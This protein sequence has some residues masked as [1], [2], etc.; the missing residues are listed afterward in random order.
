MRINKLEF[1]A[2][3]PFPDSHC[4]D[5]DLLGDSALFLIDGP[6]GAGKSTIIDA[7]TYAI[8]GE[9]AGSASDKTRIRSAHASPTMDT[10]V[11][12]TFSTQAGTFRVRRSPEYLKPAKKGGGSVKK[13]Q[14]IFVEEQLP[15]GL[16]KDLAFQWVEAG[17]KLSE[18]VGLTRTQFAQTV[19]LPQGEFASFLR[20]ETAERQPLLEQIFSTHVYSSVLLSLKER[21]KSASDEAKE[22]TSSIEAKLNE[23]KGSANLDSET[24]TQLIALAKNPEEDGA[25]IEILNGLLQELRSIADEAESKSKLATAKNDELIATVNQR[26][27]EALATARAIEADS[28]VKK[29]EDFLKECRTSLESKDFL[30]ELIQLKLD[31]SSK[32][33]K[34]GEASN[35]VSAKAGQLEEI[36]KLE[37]D[38]PVDRKALDRIKAKLFKSKTQVEALKITVKTT[39]PKKISATQKELDAASKL[40]SKLELYQATAIKLGAELKAFADYEALVKSHKSL[41]Q[42]TK[43]RTDEAKA[44]FDLHQKLFRSRMDNLAGHLASEL[45]KGQPCSVCGSKEH[46]KKAKP[47]TGSAS[48]QELIEAAEILDQKRAAAESAKSAEDKAKGGLDAAKKKLTREKPVVVAEQGLNSKALAESEANH[49][50]VDNLTE[51]LEEL[52]VELEDQTAALDVLLEESGNLK[53]ETTELENKIKASEASLKPEILDYKSVSARLQILES[54]AELL[55]EIDQANQNTEIAKQTATTERLELEKLPKHDSFGKI[56]DAEAQLEAHKGAYESAVATGASTLKAANSL[57]SGIK[58]LKSLQGTRNKVSGS[59]KAIIDLAKWADGSNNLS[60]KLPA[61]VLQAM[62]EEVVDAANSRFSTILE[63]RYELRI[64]E[65]EVG[66]KTTRGTKGLDLVVRDR[67]TEMD[68]KP[69]TLSGGEQFCAALSL[70]LGLSDIVLSNNS[71]LSIDTFFIDEGF[72]SLDSDRL[73]QVMQMLDRLKAD[74][75]TIG[76][77]SHVDEMKAAIAEHVDVKPIGASGK[78]TISV[79]WMEPSREK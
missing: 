79:S 62:F 41:V 78:S 55:L 46:P 5:F 24:V 52:R 38:L 4:I 76:L 37:K 10:W 3:G 57:A 74:G 32:N 9:M 36:S 21:A 8:Y 42:E 50:R 66:P 31:H 71:G 20:A 35:K 64:P 53:S 65:S 56:E 47:H 44:Q 13:P 7:I 51:A 69:S 59:N 54:L 67:L 11:E 17:K 2:V 6:T 77:I 12:L 27:A 39:L 61:F 19:V 63:G 72:G 45:K 1:A 15:N 40:A 48:E 43:K 58:Q 14:K 70:A 25:S 29:A 23:I 34:W 60:Q 18:V 73:S 22:T 33:F 75:R 28:S 30:G 16:W 26:K 68:R 49:E